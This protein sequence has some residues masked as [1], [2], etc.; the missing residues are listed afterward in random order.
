MPSIMLSKYFDLTK[1][2]CSTFQYLAQVIVWQNTCETLKVPTGI[3]DLEDA[4]QQHQNLIEMIS[5]TYAEVK[6]TLY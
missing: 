1:Y 4:L 6:F 5:Q 2:S 3:E